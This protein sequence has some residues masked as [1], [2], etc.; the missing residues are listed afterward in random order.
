MKAVWEDT[1]IIEVLA[2]VPC[3]PYCDSPAAIRTK[4]ISNGDGS[5]FQRMICNQC[6]RRFRVE[7]ITVALPASGDAITWF[8]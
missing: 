2:Y 6:S 8:R 5:I 7:R 4:S 1:P 3:C